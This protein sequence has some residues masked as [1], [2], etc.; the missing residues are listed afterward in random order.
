MPQLIDV[1][2]DQYIDGLIKLRAAN[3]GSG[4][5]PVEKWLP[6]KGRHAAPLPVIAYRL[7]RKI[8]NGQRTMM[9]PTAFWQE[10]HDKPEDRGEAVIRI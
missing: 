5:L 4:S 8:L 10:G 6:S 7:A 9:L 2:L 1:T 3:P